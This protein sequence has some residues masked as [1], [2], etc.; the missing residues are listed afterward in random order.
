LNVKASYGLTSFDLPDFPVPD[1][2]A[3]EELAAEIGKHAVTLFKDEDHLLPLYTDRPRILIVGPDRY[4]DFYPRLQAALLKVG[5]EPKFDYYSAPWYG[6]EPETR[7]LENIPKEAAYYDVT[8]VFTWQSHINNLFFKDYWQVKMVKDIRRTGTNLI[9]VAMRL[10][11]D[12]VDFPQVST[13]LAT[14]G[15]NKWVMNALI[16]ILVGNQEAQGKNPFPG[17]P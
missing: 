16:D 7:F 1:Y 4:W 2:Q 14:Y 15:N 10:P 17:L 13:Y 9:V 5:L 11:T 12:I 6:Q 3:H 8:I